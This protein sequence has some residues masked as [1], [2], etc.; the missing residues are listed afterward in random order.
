MIK[1]K[2]RR[3]KNFSQNSTPSFSGRRRTGDQDVTTSFSRDRKLASEIQSEASSFGARITNIFSLMSGMGGTCVP[4]VS[5]S[6]A[7]ESILFPNFP[8]GSQ[9][10][11]AKDAKAPNA[12]HPENT[13]SQS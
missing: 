9:M 8:I 12:N 10:R 3:P 11:T 2:I 13:L 1:L 4:V 7:Q 6:K 5:I